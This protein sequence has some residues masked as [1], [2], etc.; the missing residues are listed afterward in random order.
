LLITIKCILLISKII[1]MFT[2]NKKYLHLREGL[3]AQPSY[4]LKSS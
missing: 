4:P 3:V 2:S 1:L